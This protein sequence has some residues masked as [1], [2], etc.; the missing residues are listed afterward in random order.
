MPT[1]KR[2]LVPVD[3][4]DCSRAALEYA[5]DLAQHF[6]ASLHVLHVWTPPRYM[7]SDVVLQTS[8]QSLTSVLYYARAK[9]SKEMEH[10][11]A[12]CQ[13]GDATIKGWIDIGEPSQTILEVAKEAGYDLIVMG[14]HGRTALSRLLMGSVAERVVRQ[15]H[16]PV[17]TIPPP[18]KSEVG[19]SEIRM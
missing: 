8:G 15:A 12:E 11:L 4:S 19:A 18:G 3:F 16:S 17:L 2:I 13:R 6:G 10:F 5:I 7:T 14:T 9:A 1:L